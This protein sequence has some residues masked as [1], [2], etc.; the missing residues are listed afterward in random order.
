MYDKIA[1]D[2]DRKKKSQWKSLEIFLE[3]LLERNYIFKGISADLGCGNARN[4]SLFFNETSKLIGI[5]NSIKM[6][7]SARKNIASKCNMRYSSQFILADMT[8][9]PFRDKVLDTIF[10]IA[11][12]HHVNTSNLRSVVLSQIFQILT[13]GGYFLLTVWRRYQKRFRK[14]F[15]MDYI[16]RAFYPPYAQLQVE[17]RLLEFG[18][19]NV[20]W[21][22]SEKIAPQMRFYHLFTKKELS[23]SLCNFKMREYIKLGGPN[24]RDNYFILAQK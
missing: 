24:K 8:A 6:L 1:E 3:Y 16:K 7:T 10:S 5:D 2:Y 13:D 19:I 18:D 20:P 21:K 12:L 4:F 15:I 22:S 23:Y 14:H 11:S 9:L 17:A